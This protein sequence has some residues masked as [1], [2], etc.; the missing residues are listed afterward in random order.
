MFEGHVESPKRINLVHDVVESHVNVISNITAAMVKRYVFKAFYKPCASDVTH[1]CDQTCSD[2][3]AT[4]PC[5]S[6][7][8]ESPAPNVTNPLGAARFWTTTSTAL[9]RESECM[10]AG[11]A[12]R[13]VE[14]L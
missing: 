7:T 12:M 9:R 10:N 11:G 2:C 4:P 14:C 6:A 5:A 13:R 8:S 3:M 1:I